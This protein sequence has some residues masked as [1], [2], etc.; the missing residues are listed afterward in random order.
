MA[1]HAAEACRYDRPF[2]PPVS[3]VPPSTTAVIDPEFVTASPSLGLTE[4]L[5]G[6][7]GHRGKCREEPDQD[8][9]LIIMCGP[10]RI[11]ALTAAVAVVANGVGVAPMHRAGH[12]QPDQIAAVTARRNQG[13]GVCRPR[14]L[15]PLRS[16]PE[17]S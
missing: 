2:E 7:E 14:N 1:M 17:S 11:P 4:P 5:L 13:A 9:K 16:R 3:F 10:T 8:M 6:I 15:R 12:H